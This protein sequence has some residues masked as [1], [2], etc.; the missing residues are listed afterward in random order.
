MEEE[1]TVRLE[2]I[3]ASP[4]FRL[5]LLYT[6]NWRPRGAFESFTPDRFFV[7][8]DEKIVMEVMYC[9][10]VLCE[11][12]GSCSVDVQVEIEST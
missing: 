12:E 8:V 5:C 6:Q 2:V 1:E 7:L 11:Q 9:N 3:M 10:R 4:R